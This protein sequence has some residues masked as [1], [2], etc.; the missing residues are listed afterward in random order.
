MKK[1]HIFAVFFVSMVSSLYGQME[2]ETED[3]YRLRN[4]VQAAPP[5]NVKMV[6]IGNMNAGRS[7][8]SEG[9]LFTY[10]NRSAREVRISGNFSYWRPRPMDRG[11][12]GVWFYLLEEYEGK[13]PVRYKFRVDG[14]WIYDPNNGSREDDRAGSYVS[15]AEPFRKREGRQVTWRDLPDGRIEFRLFRPVARTISLVGDFNQ[16]NPEQDLLKK[17]NDGIWRI[18]KRLHSGIYRYRFLIDGESSPD[19]YNP[20]SSS[21]DAGDVC[22]LIN[23]R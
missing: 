2:I 4:L 10:K 12:N 19:L 22:S 6:K 5:R 8:I 21:D 23:I 20:S 11:K 1:I 7:V 18:T 17:G 9:I 15:L 14:S 13:G 3:Y 16:W